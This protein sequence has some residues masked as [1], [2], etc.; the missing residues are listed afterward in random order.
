M[1]RTWGVLYILISKCASRHDGV[2]FWHLNFQKVLRA[3]GVLTLFTSKFASR[4]NSVPLF[5]L[6]LASWLRTRR[7]SEPT[8]RPSRV[9]SH[10][11]LEKHSVSRLSY[12]FAPLHLP[13]LTFSP[14]EVLPGC[15]FYLSLLSE[16]SFQTSFDSNITFNFGKTKLFPRE[17]GHIPQLQPSYFESPYI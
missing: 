5:I 8:F 10:K 12:L 9:Q 16:F 4:H 3:C 13:L 11:T 6:H 17:G 1:D 2:H 7:F 14:S 15:A